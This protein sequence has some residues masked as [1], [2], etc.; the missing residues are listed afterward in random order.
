[1]NNLIKIKSRRMI[2]DIN[3]SIES[4]V[5]FTNMHCVFILCI[6]ILHCILIKYIIQ[7]IFSMRNMNRQCLIVK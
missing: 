1:M 5:G 3:K 7:L 6:A 2:M 4:A